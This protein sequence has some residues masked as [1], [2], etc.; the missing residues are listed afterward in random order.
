LKV[1]GAT[2]DRQ[3]FSSVVGCSISRFLRHRLQLGEVGHVGYGGA[4]IAAEFLRR[5]FRLGM[6]PRDD[7]YTAR[8][9]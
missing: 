3:I 8:I 4:R 2:D 1:S 5:G 9:L 6:V 7:R